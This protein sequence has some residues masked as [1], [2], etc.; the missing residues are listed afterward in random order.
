ML[1]KNRYAMIWEEFGSW[2]ERVDIR[3]GVGVGDKDKDD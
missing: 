2:A 1:G 3:L